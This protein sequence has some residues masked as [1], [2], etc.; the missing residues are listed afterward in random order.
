MSDGKAFDWNALPLFPLQLVPVPGGR[1]DLRVF[2]VRYLDM[3]GRASQAQRPFGVIALRSGQEVRQAPESFGA[4]REAE[5]FF[6]VG[7]LVTVAHIERPQPGL[8]TVSCAVGERF[9]LRSSELTKT[10]LWMGK[11]FAFGADLSVPVPEDLLPIAT[12]LQTFYSKL[13]VKLGEGVPLPFSSTANY[14]DCAWVSNRWCELLR[15]PIEIRQR[16][17]QLDNPLMRLELVGDLMRRQGI[18]LK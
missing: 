6:Q 18:L 11:C 10:G 16:L 14:N 5:A 1:L 13:Q 8:M 3:V 12:T 7:C 17:M 4:V 9:H 2:E 15:L